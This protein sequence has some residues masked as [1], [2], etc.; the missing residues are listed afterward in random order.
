MSTL[1]EIELAIERL[2]DR[3]KSELRAWMDSLGSMEEAKR[4]QETLSQLLQ[5]QIQRLATAIKRSEF[6]ANSF[7]D[8]RGDA[9]PPSNV[10][11]A[12]YQD[13]EQWAAAFEQWIKSNHDVS[14]VA[15]DSRESIYAGRGE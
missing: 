12:K 4:R 13:K 15:D 2:S 7:Q 10:Q 8:L 5:K 6:S 1:Q 9:I 11:P 3:E 14:G